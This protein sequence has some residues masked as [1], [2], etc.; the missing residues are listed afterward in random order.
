MSEPTIL[1]VHLN[2]DGSIVIKPH[3][4]AP[5]PDVYVFCPEVEINNWRY[6]GGDAD[7]AKWTSR[8]IDMHADDDDANEGGEEEERRDAEAAP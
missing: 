2:E 8:E 6:H 1:Q 3:P 4:S 5:K 7:R